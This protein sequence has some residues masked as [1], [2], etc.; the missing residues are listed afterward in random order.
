MLLLPPCSITARSALMLARNF[1]D[2]VS[3]LA[4]EPLMGPEMIKNRNVAFY[5]GSDFPSH[6]SCSSYCNL[7]PSCLA[8]P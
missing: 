1:I 6:Q 8:K 7:E 4:G 2:P 3:V 5:D